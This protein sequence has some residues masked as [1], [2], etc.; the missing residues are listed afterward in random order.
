MGEIASAFLYEI[1]VS[2]AICLPF[3]GF[4]KLG[5]YWVLLIIT[6]VLAYI[7]YQAKKE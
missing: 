6:L 3:N 4:V 5:I 1:L 2:L 7:E